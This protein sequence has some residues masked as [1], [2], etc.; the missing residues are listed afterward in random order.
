MNTGE[1]DLLKILNQGLIPSYYVAS[2][3]N[4]RKSLKAYVS[5]YLI[6]EVFQ[7][8]L[9]R[10]IQAFSRFFDALA[11]CQGELINF[12]NFASDCGVDAKTVQEYF[13]ILEDTLVGTMVYPYSKRNSREI[14][15]HMPKFFLFDVGVGGHIA[16]RVIR[17]EKGEQF[18]RAMKHFIFMELQAYKQYREKDF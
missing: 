15:T 4:C 2:E 5:D 17:E 6:Q 9:T 14:I 8:G 16:R 10:N 7:E 13:H 1:C 18:C 11:Y 3:S 12:A